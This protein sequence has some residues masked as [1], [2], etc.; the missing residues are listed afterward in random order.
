MDIPIL[1]KGYI[2][3]DSN[4]FKDKGENVM[5]M[6]EIIIAWKNGLLYSKFM[7]VLW[8]VTPF[9]FLIATSIVEHHIKD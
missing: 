8:I 5:Y 1:R 6:Q 9:I 4:C 3:Y 7:V 2:K